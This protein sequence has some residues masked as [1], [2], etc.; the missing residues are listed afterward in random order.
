[1]IIAFLRSPQLAAVLLDADHWCVD[2]DG[3]IQTFMR[4]HYR[5]TI[6]ECS[7]TTISSSWTGW[8]YTGTELG[9]DEED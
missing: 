7:R 5:W 4:P 9:F 8:R 6:D 1:M 2:V 3:R